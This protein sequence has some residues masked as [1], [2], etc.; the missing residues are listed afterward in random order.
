MAA[1]RP[2][3][4]RRPAS[5]LVAA[6]AASAVVVLVVPGVGCRGPDSYYRHGQDG[7]GARGGNGPE[8]GPID[9]GGGDRPEGGS[10]TGGHAG[11]PDLAV[12]GAGGSVACA[13]CKLVLLY[14]CGGPDANQIRAAFKVA[15]RTMESVRLADVTFRY[16][17]ADIGA[18]AHEFV[19]DFALLG[20]ENIT[21]EFVP[22]IPPRLGADFYAEI[23]FLDAA[24]TLEPF[25]DTG[26][27]RVRI[28]RADQQTITQI[29]DYSF[30]CSKISFAEWNRVTVYEKGVLVSG[31]EPPVRPDPS[32]PDAGAEEVAGSGVQMGRTLCSGAC[33]ADN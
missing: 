13:S 19:C 22:V 21:H 14:A 6:L 23:G 8:A 29:D 1:D 27:I 20:K 33:D 2:I 12:D 16:W 10:G 3:H 4:L 26:E 31:I 15:S 18:V 5:L 30:D 11:R 9:R 7:G 28:S 17:Y 32:L 24:G 25:G